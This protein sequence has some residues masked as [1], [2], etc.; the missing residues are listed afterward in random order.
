MKLEDTSTPIN[1]GYKLLKRLQQIAVFEDDQEAA[2]WDADSAL[3]EFAQNKVS[4]KL[5][6]EIEEAYEE[7]EKWY[8]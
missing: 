6:A 2:H 5:G 3:L 4:D 7:I 8:A 1:T